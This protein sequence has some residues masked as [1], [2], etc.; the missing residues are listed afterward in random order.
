M[1]SRQGTLAVL[2][3]VR[4]LAERAWAA[5]LAA[6]VSP[7]DLDGSTGQSSPRPNA[8]ARKSSRLSCS[9]RSTQNTMHAQSACRKCCKL[10]AVGGPDDQKRVGDR[11]TFRERLDGQALV[12]HSAIDVTRRPKLGRGLRPNQDAALA[13]IC[14][15]RDPLDATLRVSDALSTESG[16]SEAVK[17]IESRG[18]S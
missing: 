2:F 15:S 9:S 10:G 7:D 6:L 11:R 8:A 1:W 12:G 17:W 16:Q 5:A 13:R 3:S 18:V 4:V 14:L